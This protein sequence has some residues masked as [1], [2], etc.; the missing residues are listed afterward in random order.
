MT[1]TIEN[2]LKTVI[3]IGKSR[4]LPNGRLQLIEI[5]G[6]GFLVTSKGLKLLVT[7]NHVITR[8][9]DSTVHE[10]LSYWLNKQDN[11]FRVTYFDEIQKG[12][13]LV[14]VRDARND[15]A[16]IPIVLNHDLDD[17][18][19]IPESMMVTTDIDIGEDV[20]FIGYPNSLIESSDI[21]P[22]VRRGII[23]RKY[24]STNQY[25]I[26]G[27]STGGNSGGPVF[28]KP[29]PGKKPHLIGMV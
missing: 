22:F 2:M 17:Y 26:D 7:A 1:S 3:L 21:T 10:N 18:R 19:I 12:L 15:I 11:S 14:W 6:T 23:S 5:M 16:I 25:I 28:I 20:L 8:K 9:E 13:D 27:Y 4:T 24:R 29:S